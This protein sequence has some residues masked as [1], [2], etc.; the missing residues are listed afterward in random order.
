MLI[1]NID[2]NIALIKYYDVINGYIKVYHNIFDAQISFFLAVVIKVIK[3]FIHFVQFKEYV[4]LKKK[5][6]FVMR[7]T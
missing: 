5:T 7:I 4:K 3:L 2:F 6:M 1:E